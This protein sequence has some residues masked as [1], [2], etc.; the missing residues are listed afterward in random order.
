MKATPILIF[1]F[2]FTHFSSFA[3][4]EFISSGF[5]QM[6]D[7]LNY[8]VEE[9]SSDC[10]R[11]ASED[12]NERKIFVKE[13][14]LSCQKY[15]DGYALGKYYPCQVS[16][17]YITGGLNSEGKSCLLKAKEVYQTGN[18]KKILMDSSIGIFNP[19][20]YLYLG[21]EFPNYRGMSVY[22]EK[23]KFHPKTQFL[24]ARDNFSIKN[25]EKASKIQFQASFDKTKLN[26]VLLDEYRECIQ[27]KEDWTGYETCRK[28]GKL[29]INLR[30]D[31]SFQ[32]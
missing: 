20:T 18:G 29:K 1:I 16:T 28:L 21:N 9:C 24:K 7:H 14:N 4:G 22:K 6:K 17:Y 19:V 30:E 13:S 27:K 3:K 15:K 10:D 5:K 26:T 12:R 2:L 25:E 11:I 23:S 32:K 31:C 8:E